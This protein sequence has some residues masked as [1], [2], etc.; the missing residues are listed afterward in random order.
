MFDHGPNSIF[1]NSIRL[2]GQTYTYN[3]LIQ[4]EMYIWNSNYEC[5]QYVVNNNVRILVP[6]DDKETLSRLSKV[7]VS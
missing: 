3:G 6:G 4:I 7:I 5:V 2:F 1:L